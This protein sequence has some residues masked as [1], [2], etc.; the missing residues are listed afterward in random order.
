MADCTSAGDGEL[1]GHVM[2]FDPFAPDVL[3]FKVMSKLARRAAKVSMP[4]LMAA[5]E[6]SLGRLQDPNSPMCPQE[7]ANC[8]VEAG[9]EC[10]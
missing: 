8:S 9:V 4:S 2:Y 6:V 1:C 3:R 10:N 5:K 7:T